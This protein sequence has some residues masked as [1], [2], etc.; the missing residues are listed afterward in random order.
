M[1]PNGLSVESILQALSADKSLVLFNT[2]AHASTDTEILM[3]K[4]ALS[5]KQ[6]YS[7]MSAL[8]RAGLVK[9]RNKKYFL[10]SFGMIVYEAQLI[11]GKALG[12]YWKLAA[13][14]SF[15]MSSPN[16]HFPVEEY[17]RIIDSVMEGN[18]EIKNI[19]LRYNDDNI[20][21]AGN[22]KPT[23]IGS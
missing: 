17:N 8:L 12:S 16:P 19:L 1:V 10:S 9:R 6:Y 18:N 22:E 5:R 3:K 2:I 21:I 14:D 4:L 7:K 11:I 23:T 15:E 13:I 20:T